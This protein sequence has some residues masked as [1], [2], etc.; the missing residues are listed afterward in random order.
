[1][2]ICFRLCLALTFLLVA[3]GGAAA[4]ITEVALPTAAADPQ[5]ITV[6]PDGALWFTEYRGNRIG[7][8]STAAPH[9]VTEIELPQPAHFPSRIT[10][11]QDGRLWFTELKP[12]AIASLDPNNPAVIDEIDHD[13]NDWPSA[14][15][16]LP[17][18]SIWYADELRPQLT[19]I[20]GSNHDSITT[21]PIST[22][23]SRLI[24]GPSGDLWYAGVNLLGRVATTPPYAESD[25]RLTARNG[26]TA[27]AAASDG[28]MWATGFSFGNSG[29][30]RLSGSGFIDVDRMAL[31][32]W[33]YSVGIVRGSDDNLW[34]A[35]GRGNLMRVSTQPPYAKT[36]FPLARASL[37][38]DIVSGPD[39]NLW[40]TQSGTNSI[41]II[42]PD[43]PAPQPATVVVNSTRDT[44]LAADD[45]CTL[46][47]A[48]A[49]IDAPGDVSGGDCA[50]AAGIDDTITFH[51]P[52]YPAVVRL[53]ASLLIDRRF[54]IRGPFPGTPQ[55]LRIDGFGRNRIL[56]IYD[57]EIE[58]H[59]VTFQHGTFYAPFD[60]NHAGG[61]AVSVHG[62][63]RFFH[64]DFV[65]NHNS[66]GGA[67]YADEESRLQFADCRLVRNKSTIG[68]VIWSD[69]PVTMDRC[70]M[71][72]NVG[73][74]VKAVTLTVTNS[75]FAANRNGSAIVAATLL[76]S[77]STFDRNRG[78][79][80][81]VQASE[82][83]VT[84]STFTNN[85]GDLLSS[86][87]SSLQIGNS[88]MTRCFRSSCRSSGCPSIASAGHNLS[89]NSCVMAAPGDLVATDPGL[90][91]LAAFGGPTRTRA[92][93][94]GAG[95]P[96]AAC[97][98]R[99]PAIDAG[100][101]TV[102]DP[103]L[104]LSH[105]QRGELRRVG[106]HVDIGATESAP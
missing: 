63:A 88:I 90:T 75:T 78:A 15:L 47:E 56:R 20:D 80:P 24:L 53:R 52:S 48:I 10:S 19:R 69:G 91:R 67:I 96:R 9:I 33:L 44:Q 17:D 6:G 105:D 22:R 70:T 50:A 54:T 64:T 28:T 12:R 37:P 51:L 7:R 101:D 73:G 104:A 34:I 87:G 100:D 21:I 27:L 95:E 31:P 46:R 82:G 29:L 102:L 93:C 76:L 74:G 26:S 72:N 103:P 59:D 86:R 8:I 36:I 42:T 18:G 62:E 65:C 41:A 45:E 85:F 84:S 83:T 43:T 35:D 55:S 99:S 16:G 40:V 68:P 13:P 5:S 77:N 58:T 14:I 81:V 97:T 11:G 23:A 57:G 39:G 1:M 30:T 92:L 98:S 49:N 60:L 89:D 4:A 94:T 61:G 32:F 2:K 106:A 66:F 79:A 25:V 71:Q 3:H 38:T